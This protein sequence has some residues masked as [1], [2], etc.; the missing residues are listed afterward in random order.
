MQAPPTKLATEVATPLYSIIEVVPW[1]T[2]TL[3]GIGNP[4]NGTER[5]MKKMNLK[6]QF[7]V[8][9]LYHY[10]F[11]TNIRFPQLGLDLFYLFRVLVTFQML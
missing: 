6:I 8:N 11:T 4:R 9:L 10:L 1:I 5:P 3:S 2:I 7:I